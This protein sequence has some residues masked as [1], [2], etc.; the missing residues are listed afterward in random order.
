[1]GHGVRQ[2][3]G[4]PAPLAL[5]HDGIPLGGADAGGQD[6]TPPSVVP[7]GVEIRHSRPSCSRRRLGRT[8]GSSDREITTTST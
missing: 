1:M 5:T 6:L 8:Q 7:V 3:H 2:S 4:L